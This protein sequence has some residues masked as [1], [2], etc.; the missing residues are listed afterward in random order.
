MRIED[1]RELVSRGDC[2]TV[3]LNEEKGIKKKKRTYF[4]EFIRIKTEKM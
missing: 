1:E 3:K 4:C 2:R